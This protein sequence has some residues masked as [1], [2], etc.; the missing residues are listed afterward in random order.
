M[1]ENETGSAAR[2]RP[3]AERDPL[4]TPGEVAQWLHVS[5]A[6]VRDHASGRRRPLLPS[7]KLGKVL[8]FRASDVEGFVEE[9]RQLAER[10]GLVA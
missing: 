6:W 10:R 3:S 2:S 1:N 8:R 5:P 4:L 9:C 7:L